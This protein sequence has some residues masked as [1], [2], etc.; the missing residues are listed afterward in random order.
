VFASADVNNQ[1]VESTETNNASAA[2]AIHVGPDLVESAL[3]APASAPAGS[4]ITVADTALNQGGGTAGAS[5]TTFYLSTNLALDSSDV[6]IGSRP[7]PQLAPGQSNAGTTAVTIPAGT[8]PGLYAIL[9]V[10]DS[11][12]AVVE[13]SETNNV[14]S[15]LIQVK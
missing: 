3:S 11:A 15:I 12:G 13:T 6:A 5:T 7:I 4:T 2:A 10:S 1:V 14:R 9:A 8:A